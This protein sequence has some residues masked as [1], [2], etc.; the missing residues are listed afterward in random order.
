MTWFDSAKENGQKRNAGILPH[1]TTLRVRMTT[2]TSNGNDNRKDVIQ[3]SFT[4]FRMT[5]TLQ[6]DDFY[7]MTTF[8]DALAKTTAMATTTVE[9][10]TRRYA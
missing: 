10:G 3:G 2:R 6:D 4:A 7:R 1:S 8:G 5:A 9:H